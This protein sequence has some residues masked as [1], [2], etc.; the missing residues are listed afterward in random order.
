M[1]VPQT[2]VWNRG[3]TFAQIDWGWRGGRTW[4]GWSWRPA[5][6]WSG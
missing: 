1:M 6:W 2:G 5:G 4:T 3:L